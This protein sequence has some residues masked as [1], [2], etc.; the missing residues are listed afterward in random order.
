MEAS[1]AL[2]QR[3]RKQI[4]GVLLGLIMS[5]LYTTGGAAVQALDKL[6]PLFQLNA[7]RLVGKLVSIQKP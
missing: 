1:T 3:N 5:I 2:H 6:V 4:V 7:I